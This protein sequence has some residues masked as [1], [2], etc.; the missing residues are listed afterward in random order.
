MLFDA[1]N[2]Q[3]RQAVEQARQQAAYL[4]HSELGVEH[5]L[6][7]VSEQWQ[8]KGSEVLRA[9]GIGHAD[10][11]QAV[12]TVCPS[13]DEQVVAAEM[14]IAPYAF[15]VIVRAKAI[16]EY[17]ECEEVGTGHF[18]YAMVELD[19][20]IVSDIFL[21]LGVDL[22]EFR[23][24]VILRVDPNAAAELAAAMEEHEQAEETL[25]DTTLIEESPLEATEENADDVSLDSESADGALES[26]AL[27]SGDAKN[28][29]ADSGDAVLED[30][31]VEPAVAS[32]PAAE[33][34]STEESVSEATSTEEPA[35]EPPVVEETKLEE[36]EAD[37]PIPVPTTSFE[38]V[39]ESAPVEAT[40]WEPS[41]MSV[42]E[43][44][45]ESWI[46]TR[47]SSSGA[48]VEN[49]APATSEP[50]AEEPASE[51][52]SESVSE[53]VAEDT[54]EPSSPTIAFELPQTSPSESPAVSSPLSPATESTPFAPSDD[55]PITI[56]GDREFSK[57]RDTN[58]DVEGEDIP[59]VE[60][61]AGQEPDPIPKS[62]PR[63]RAKDGEEKKESYRSSPLSP[64]VD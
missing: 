42:T 32:E 26:D 5:L 60:L 1:F 57:G 27:D 9:Q 30:P 12:A 18:L 54:E 46:Q 47:D 52:V 49:S 7:G 23:D 13:G 24:A 17:Y 38:P 31:D 36:A 10:L 4:Q 3:A 2:P 6:L 43:S 22:E 40:P 44:L 61:V 59:F 63:K 53:A 45:A 62:P 56:P 34:P 39:E 19:N 16:A 14:P 51:P 33:A 21:R 15:Q 50:V 55:Q 25:G 28:E 37:E 58:A 29:I 35:T 41:Q 11:T 8:G 48:G 64:D 20:E